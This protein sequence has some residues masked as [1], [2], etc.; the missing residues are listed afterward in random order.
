MY[1]YISMSGCEPNLSLSSCMGTSS[2]D[3]QLQ[4]PLSNVPILATVLITDTALVKIS[5]MIFSTSGFISKPDSTLPMALLL[6]LMED[7]KA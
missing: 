7:N 4:L 6:D 2:H 3:G 1:I 5:S